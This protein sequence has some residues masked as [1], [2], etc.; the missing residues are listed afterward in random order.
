MQQEQTNGSGEDKTA[1]VRFI[2]ENL[3]KLKIAEMEAEIKKHTPARGNGKS[4]GIAIK[5]SQL[6][7][8]IEAY[9]ELL[10]EEEK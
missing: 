2:P 6:I 8:K 4:L 5:I 9:R 1:F 10:E 7:A 3:I